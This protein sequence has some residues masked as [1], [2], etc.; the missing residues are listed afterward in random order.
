[1]NKKSTAKKP[2]NKLS[3][4][5]A[6]DVCFA[7]VLANRPITETRLLAAPISVD[8]A[9]RPPETKE[10]RTHTGNTEFLHRDIPPA[11]AA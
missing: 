1:M 2:D 11:K 3:V 9:E 10:I 4:N 7:L 8:F 6:E 5:W